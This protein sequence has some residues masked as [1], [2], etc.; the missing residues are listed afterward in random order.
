MKPQLTSLSH[1]PDYPI[2]F[3]VPYTLSRAYE[4]NIINYQGNVN[5]NHNEVTLH[6]TRMTKI[7]RLFILSVGKDAEQLELS[8][9][10]DGNVETAQPL[11]ENSLTVFFL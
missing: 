11:W 1:W 7:K 5:Q 3:L 8:Y 9:I 4:D 6:T 2:I 10:A